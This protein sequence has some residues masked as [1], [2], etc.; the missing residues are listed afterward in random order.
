MLESLLTRNNNKLLDFISTL[1]KGLGFNNMN[2]FVVV[3]DP[4]LFTRMFELHE[5]ENSGALLPPPKFLSSTDVIDFSL[6]LDSNICWLFFYHA[7]FS[8]RHVIG[9]THGRRC[10]DKW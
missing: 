8:V 4:V 7:F 9:F 10:P 6:L 1:A 2:K 3:A 5:N